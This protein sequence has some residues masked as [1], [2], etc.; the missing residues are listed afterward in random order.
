[1]HTDETCNFIIADFDDGE[2]QSDITAF[3]NICIERG[4]PIAT[5]LE[6]FCQNVIRLI[7]G[8]KTKETGD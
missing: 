3:G 2:W 7:G 4:I 5:E 6:A 8:G 1:M